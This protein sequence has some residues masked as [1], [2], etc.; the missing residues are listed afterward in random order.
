MLHG[1]TGTIVVLFGS[2][3][4]GKTTLLEK[5]CQHHS[6]LFSRLV[7]CTSRPRRHGETDGCDYYFRESS[8]FENSENLILKN[9]S[10]EGYHY[11]LDPAHLEVPQPYALITLRKKG[12]LRLIQDGYRMAVVSLTVTDALREQRM[13]ER[14]DAEADIQARMNQDT[15][16][17]EVESLHDI[18]S[19]VP[20]HFV[21]S[22]LAVEQNRISV[23]QFLSSLYPT[24]LS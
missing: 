11:A 20:I 10:D 3:G 2:S 7:T 6:E 1:G 16:S 8:F 24:P 19:T 22:S 17:V 14:G 15:R 12:V 18:G 23:V 4:S 13:R 9:V 21:D 5:L